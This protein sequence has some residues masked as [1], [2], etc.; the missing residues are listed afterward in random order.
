MESTA[1]SPGGVRTT[2]E[3]GARLR[4]LQ[5]WSG[6]SYREIHRRVLRSRQERGIAELP[7]FNTT[8][9]CLSPGRTRLD[10]ELVVDIA[11][12]VLGSESRAAEWRQAHQVVSGLAADASVVHV[13]DRVESEGDSF[14]GRASAVTAATAALPRFRR[15]RRCRAGR[16]AGRAGA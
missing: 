6:L 15:V 7:A 3:L 12:A 2:A 14:V 1:P 4:A 11:R 8:Y 16:L 9:R 13:G 5:V 10:V